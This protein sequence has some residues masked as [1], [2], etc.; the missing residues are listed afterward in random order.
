MKHSMVLFVFLFVIKGCNQTTKSN[1][2]EN[3]NSSSSIN[4]VYTDKWGD[5]YL[6]GKVSDSILYEQPY[7]EKFAMTD[8][9]DLNEDAISQL[10]GVLNNFDIEVFFGSWCEDS[11][12]HLPD[13]FAVLH[14]INYDFDQFNMVALGDEGKWYKESPTG[15]HEGKNIEY[16]PTIIVYKDGKEINRIVESPI[17]SVEEDLLSIISGQE[18]NHKYEIDE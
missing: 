9:L 14:H 12:D 18:Y 11:Q 2:S 6:L 8:S 17:N 15:E 1:E 4:Q 5:S 10:K 16:V 7:N 3:E 13:L